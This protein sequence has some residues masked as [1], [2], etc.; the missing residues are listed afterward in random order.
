MNT[1]VTVQHTNLTRRRLL[2][3]PLAAT[4]MYLSNRAVAAACTVTPTTEDGPLYPPYPFSWVSDLTRIPGKAGVATGQPL[5]IH[6]QVLNHQ[7]VPVPNAVVEIWQADNNG[8]YNH[9]RA[10]APGAIDPF[11][12]ISPDKLDPFFQYF[13]RVKTDENG[14]YLIK[15]IVPRWYRVFEINRAAHIHFKVRSTNNGVM[16]TELYFPGEEQTEL[17]AQDRVFQSRHNRSQLVVSLESAFATK[18]LN[19]PA[20]PKAKYAHYNFVF[21]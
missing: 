8:Y 15:T 12:E 18:E 14:R 6:G 2:T 7:C 11:W 21:A 20:D 4:A 16:T 9:P 13:S 1:K 3:I 5:Y 10:I 17:Q 19:I